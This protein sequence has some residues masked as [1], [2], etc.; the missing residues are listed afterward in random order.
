[1]QAEYWFNFASMDIPTIFDLL[2]IPDE[3]RNIAP[4]ITLAQAHIQMERLRAEA[5]Q[6]YRRLSMGHHP[7]KG[8]DTEEMKQLNEAY[9][10]LKKIKITPRRK[11][12]VSIVIGVQVQHTTGTSSYSS[13]TNTAL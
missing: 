3:L 7:D 5:K 11:P 2:E 13:T 8:G 6:N 1:M 9:E 12:M 10:E 4:N